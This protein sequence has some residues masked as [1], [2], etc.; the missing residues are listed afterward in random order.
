[1]QFTAKSAKE[2]GV[3]VEKTSRSRGC[4]LISER[5]SV[6]GRQK[7]TDLALE[8]FQV[9]TPRRP[10]QSHPSWPHDFL[11]A[12]LPKSGLTFDHFHPTKLFWQL[13]RDGNSHASCMSLATAASPKPSVRVPWRVGD[14]VVGRRNAGWTRSKG[15]W[16]SLCPCQHL[17]QWL[18]V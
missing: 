2:Q 16:T 4:R 10:L 6:G 12:H 17:S 18:P 5:G 11:R 9:I 8:T 3:R 15:G 7:S 14:A 1:M 13:S